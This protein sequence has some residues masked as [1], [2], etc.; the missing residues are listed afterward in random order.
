MKDKIGLVLSGGGVRAIAHIG[1]I[2]VLLEKNIIPTEV[3]GTS[4]GAL[5]GALYAGGFEPEEM[6]NFFEETPLLKLSFYAR[7]KPGMLDS[8]K[9]A[10]YF[11]KYFPIDS[12]ESLKYPLTVTATDLFNSKLDF[13]N[14]G[15][16]IK[17]LIASSALPPFFSPIE[18]NGTYYSDGGI[19]NNFPIEPLSLNCSKIIG[20]F[21]NPVSKCEYADINTS[22]KLLYRVYHIGLDVNNIKKFNQCNYV[23]S[24]PNIDDIGVLD[25]DAIQK[26]FDLGYKHA[27]NEINKIIDLI[28]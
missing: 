18:V 8:S 23:F 21:V 4:A 6:L 12:F 2:K 22:F 14:S 25:G 19:L 7:N 13:F 28:S 9:Y 24:P 5:V 27:L 3:A 10:K 20:S 11:K 16:I 17:P 15:E 1:L 26:S